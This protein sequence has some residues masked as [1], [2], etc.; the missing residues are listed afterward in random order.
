VIPAATAPPPPAPEPV[1]AATAEPT[2]ALPA[3][4]PPAPRPI[5]LN[6]WGVAIENYAPSVRLGNT[7]ALNSARA[8][9][10]TYL[11]A[12]HNR[13]HPLFADQCLGSLGVL[14]PGHPLSQDL[15]VHI[16]IV[17]AKDTGKIVRMG[18]VKISGVTAFDLAALDAVSRAAPFG[19]APDAIA[20]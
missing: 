6:R 4:D 3:P 18:V 14:P 5:Q 15:S 2:N 8:P 7:T 12:V 19:K 10:P 13:I 1:A 9:F 16:E 17:L 20:S 11:V